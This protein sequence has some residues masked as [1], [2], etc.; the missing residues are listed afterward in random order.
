[1]YVC[2]SL[3]LCVYVGIC[4]Y[5]SVSIYIILLDGLTYAKMLQIIL[6]S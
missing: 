2:V 3:Y 6:E 5:N 1:M 4:V